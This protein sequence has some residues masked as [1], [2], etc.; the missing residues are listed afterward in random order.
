MVSFDHFC[1]IFD[2]HA[3]EPINMRRLGHFQLLLTKSAK[4][5]GVRGFAR[6]ISVNLIY[7][8]LESSFL[9]VYHLGA[10]TINPNHISAKCFDHLTTKFDAHRKCH[11]CDTAPKASVNPVTR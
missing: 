5:Y 10:L 2:L 6:K 8:R 7:E 1:P 4:F 3:L 9:D 11:M